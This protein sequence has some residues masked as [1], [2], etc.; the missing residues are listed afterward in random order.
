MTEKDYDRVMKNIDTNWMWIGS[1]TP[2]GYGKLSINNKT[3]GAHRIVWEMFR[4]PIPKGMFVCHH[5]DTPGC[6]NPYHMFLGT[7][8]DNMKDCASKGRNGDQKKTHCPKGHP[9]SGTNLR[10]RRGFREC[11]IC[12]REVDNARYARNREARKAQA[13]AY[14]ARKKLS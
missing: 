14:R 8:T 13:R 2:N 11:M 10:M 5:C 6:V 12:V 4:G 7:H 9:Y 3:V 1:K